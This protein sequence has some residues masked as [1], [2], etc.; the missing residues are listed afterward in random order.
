MAD[1]AELC[2]LVTELIERLNEQGQERDKMEG[3][4]IA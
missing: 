2:E 3:N 4:R 1:V